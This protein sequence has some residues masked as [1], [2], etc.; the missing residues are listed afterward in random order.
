M[1][2][3]LSFLAA[4]VVLALVGYVFVIFVSWG[5]SVFANSTDTVKGASI[6][7]IT[8]IV[9]VLIGRFLEQKREQK[10]RLNA[11]KI[12]VYK[13]FFEFY[14]NS[15]SDQK[16]GEGSDD[17][18]KTLREMLEFQ[19][20][21]IFWGSDHV[22]KEYLN[23][24]DRLNEFTIKAEEAEAPQAS[25]EDL[26]K[27]FASVAA[28]LV[29]MRKDVGYTFTSFKAHD[30]ARLQLKAGQEESLIIEKLK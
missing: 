22:I 18:D 15:F 10:Q 7:A 6:A 1:K 2:K 28:L 14:F 5:V 20:N 21:L 30:L 3:N 4:L 11:E 29:A 27:V 26:A 16:F 17:P 19:K 23:F 25:A 12:N 8:S 13:A 9:L 24:K